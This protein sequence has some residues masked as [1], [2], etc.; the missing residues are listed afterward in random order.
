MQEVN[1]RISFEGFSGPE[2]W[3]MGLPRLSLLLAFARTLCVI[4]PTVLFTWNP[5]DLLFGFRRFYDLLWRHEHGN[6][7]CGR[8]HYSCYAVAILLSIFTLEP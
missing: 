5:L 2:V 3:K 1:R 4:L 7:S 8:Y 6:S